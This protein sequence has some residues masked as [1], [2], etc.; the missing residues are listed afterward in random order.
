MPGW[1]P[2]LCP[3]P[4]AAPHCGGSI[5]AWSCLAPLGQLVMLRKAEPTPAAAALGC[6]GTW[7]PRLHGHVRALHAGG[8]CPAVC[9]GQGPALLAILGPESRGRASGF[10]EL[11]TEQ[12]SWLEGAPA[13]LLPVHR[14]APGA[15]GWPS[16]GQAAMWRGLRLLLRAGGVGRPGWPS[17]LGSASRQVDGRRGCGWGPS[18]AP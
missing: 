1:L 18:H 17:A 3:P 7:G 12:H 4:H 13:A 6:P 15:V 8:L 9:L 10:R 2:A 11:G 16:D 5:L 14:C